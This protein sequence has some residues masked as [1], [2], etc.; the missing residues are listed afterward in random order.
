MA[1][2]YQYPRKNPPVGNDLVLI[3]DTEDTL[4]P[5]ATKSVTVQSI[6]DLAT[7]GAAG[8]SSLNTLT[9]ALTLVGGTSITAVS[10]G[11]DTITIN[12]EIEQDLELGA[13]N[14]TSNSGVRNGLVNIVSG[15][16]GGITLNPAAGYVTI[17]QNTWPNA[18]GSAGQALITSGSG[19][20]SWST[21]GDVV[22]PSS[23]TDNAIA[24]FDTTTGKLIQNSLATI[25]DTGNITAPDFIGDLN[26]AVRFTG[27][28]IGTD[29]DKG[30]VVYI[31][32]I[33]G[34]TP[35]IELAQSDSFTTMTAFGIAIDDIPQNNTGEIASFGSVKGLDVVNFGETSITFGIGDT[36]YVSSTEA[37]KLTN[38]APTSE[39]N[40][41]QNIGKIERATPTTNMTIKVGGAG[42]ANAT[43]NLDS[44]KMFLGSSANQAVSVAMSGDVTISNTGV[45]TVGVTATEVPYG[46]VSGALTSEAAFTYDDTQNKLRADQVDSNSSTAKQFTTGTS[47]ITSSGGAATWNAAQGAY[48][49]FLLTEN[50]TLEITNLPV[51]TPAVLKVTQDGASSFNITAYT[52]AGGSVVWPGGTVPTITAAVNSVDI[53]SFLADATDIYASANQD[54]K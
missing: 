26:G 40:L 15:G 47:S 7:V 19:L 36:V 42:R 50:T 53:I 24:R 48:G 8:V 6:V 35:E 17:D 44:A 20:L 38:V 23:A 54:F 27:K 10:S 32:G 9:G 13:Y 3:S 18:D 49:E 51:G 22:G 16:T 2:Q 29:I 31:S 11:G 4:T 12:L 33:S 1:I 37:G 46:N 52:V 14:I 34:N 41:I 43:P 28:A 30:E 21:L 5:N 45:T 25:D 39:G